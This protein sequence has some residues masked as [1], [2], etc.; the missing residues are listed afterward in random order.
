VI[1][2][3]WRYAAGVSG[4]VTLPA[5]ATVKQIVVHATTPG[6]MTI[7]GGASIPLAAGASPAF[8]FGHN[9]CVAGETPGGG[10]TI[11][12]TGTDSYFVESI[13][14]GFGAT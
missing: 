14:P 11:V 8:R 2:G 10:L 4:T 1:Q 6:S 5:G 7:F 9:V 12:F 13:G 3:T